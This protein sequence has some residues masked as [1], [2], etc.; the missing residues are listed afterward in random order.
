MNTSLL[1]LALLVVPADSFAAK[2]PGRTPHPLAP[3]LPVLTDK[4][5]KRF[6]D[7]ID[8]FIKFDTGKLGGADGRK[9]AVEFHQLGP[10]AVFLLIDGFNQAANLQDTCPA[11]LIGKKI[12]SILGRSEDLELLTFA[13]ESLGAGVTARRHL[14]VLK[15]LQLGCM[16]RRT[17]VQK[18]LAS[19]PTYLFQKTLA[20]RQV[21]ELL[22]AVDKER[23][24]QLKMVLIEL[25]KRDNPK[26]LDALGLAAG[27]AERDVGDLARALLAK[28]LGR[29]PASTLTLQLH[30][31]Q[32]EVRAAA[33]R[34][35]AGRRPP[36]GNELIAL[37][38][39]PEESVRQ[40]ARQSLLQLGRGLDYG[41]QP[42]AST[43][44]RAQAV[45]QWRS[46]WNKR[47]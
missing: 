2:Y 1:A 43:S 5:E 11:V 39:D 27:Q 24:P 8:R 37:L 47:K 7:I 42:G 45:Q 34:A 26:V 41:P 25:E 20:T 46:W 21:D 16:L 10:E 36:L 6:A 28:H 29:Q 31:D 38:E 32:A 17:A 22:A 13:R 15:D 14:G 40:A 35:A 4:E 3:S 30:H 18:K 12:A 19:N 23:G 44:Q 33:A 9:A